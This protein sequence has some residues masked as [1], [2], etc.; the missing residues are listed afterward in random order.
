MS[1][2]DPVFILMGYGSNHQQ[3]RFR[4]DD[5]MFMAKR[6]RISIREWLATSNR[7]FLATANQE[8]SRIV[9]QGLVKSF[10]FRL[11]RRQEVRMWRRMEVSKIF[12]A[13]NTKTKRYMKIIIQGLAE[14]RRLCCFDNF[15]VNSRPKINCLK[16]I[17]RF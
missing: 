13:R 1:D 8:P 4:F 5:P 14:V 7:R 3:I 2:S 12:K 15:R 17:M 10:A 6:W 11:R 16:Y 9:E